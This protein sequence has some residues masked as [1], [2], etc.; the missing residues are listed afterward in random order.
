LKK[1]KICPGFTPRL[2]EK[3]GGE[4]GAQPPYVELGKPNEPRKEGRGL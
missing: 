3:K 4:K 1:E 2:V